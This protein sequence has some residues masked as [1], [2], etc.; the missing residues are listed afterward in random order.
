M[1]KSPNLSPEV[2]KRTVRMV[3][4]RCGEY[5]SLWAAIESISA[6][7]GGVPH[8]LHDWI[9]KVRSTPVYEQASPAKSES[10]SRPSDARTKR[11]AEPKKFSNWP[12][13][14]CTGGARP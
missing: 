2:R 13:F 8:N 11:F 9:K 12:A 4:E 1:K 14:F 5:R 10:A 7:I 6:K 3:Q